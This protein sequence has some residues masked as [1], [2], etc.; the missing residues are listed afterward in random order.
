MLARAADGLPNDSSIALGELINLIM[1]I[2]KV[3]GG[4][5]INWDFIAEDLA[6]TKRDV[7]IVHGANARMR[8]IS[9]KLGAPERTITSPSGHVSRYT[10][11]RAMEVLTM[12]YSGLTNKAIVACLQRQGVNAVG[13]SGADGK[14]WQGRRKDHIL[15]QE[16]EKVKV[17]S[18]SLTG[19]LD[20]INVALLRILFE[21]G[22]TPVLTV[23]AI[24]AAGELI[25]VDNDRAVA[26]MAR[27]LS[28]N[29]IVMLFEAPGL[30]AD[31]RDEGSLVREIA[32]EQFDGYLEKVQGRMRKKLLGVR[33]AFSSGA[34]EV[35][36]GDGRI[37]QP[38]SS[39]LAGNGTTLRP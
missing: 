32:G 3:G 30:L 9:E 36:F 8:E 34:K 11:A 13:L 17:I 19:V 7:V 4:K 14:I 18:D 29:T 2:L 1:F 5:E 39:A 37:P 35:Y 23:P 20:S 6:Q 33:E 12:V 38:V 25:N 27:D 16:G 28:V 10:D 24:T 15:S 21:S 26:V 31:P 22:Y